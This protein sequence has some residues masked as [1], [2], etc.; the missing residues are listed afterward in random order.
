[1]LLRCSVARI[2]I[3]SLSNVGELPE[4]NRVAHR[5]LWKAILT[6]EVLPSMVSAHHKLGQ[7]HRKRSGAMRCA[8][9]GNPP[10]FCRILCGWLMF[11]RV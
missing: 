2:E 1:M 6:V 9:C 5:S 10:N 11:L 7:P 3:N 8:G 4:Q